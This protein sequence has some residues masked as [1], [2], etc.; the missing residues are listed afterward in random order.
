MGTLELLEVFKAVRKDMIIWV[1]GIG[2]SDL[3]RNGRH[4]FLG[5]TTLRE[6]IKMVYLHDQ[7]HLRDIKRVL[8]R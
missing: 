1:L 8:N 6:M 2:E 3:E 4:P 7:I 5:L